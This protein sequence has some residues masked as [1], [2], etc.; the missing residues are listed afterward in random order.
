MG[1]VCNV[2]PNSR[3]ENMKTESSSLWAV[4]T[5]IIRRYGGH[6]AEDSV[7]CSRPT[8]HED[9]QVCLRMMTCIFHLGVG[10][11][12]ALTA[13]CSPSKREVVE[14]QACPRGPPQRRS[15]H[16]EKQACDG[17]RV[18]AVQFDVGHWAEIARLHN[19][20]LQKQDPQETFGAQQHMAKKL[21]D[22]ATLSGDTPSATPRRPPQMPSLVKP[23]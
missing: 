12:V 16:A 21:F 8:I 15:N 4:G 3:R 13:V 23:L 10:F 1:K 20:R 7:L 19:Y 9:G 6:H 2:H 11:E 5:L 22:P 14:A 18:C 17:G